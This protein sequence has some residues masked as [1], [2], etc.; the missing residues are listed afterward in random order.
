MMPLGLQIHQIYATKFHAYVTSNVKAGF[1]LMGSVLKIT[2]RMRVAMR[3]LP[4]VK[5][6]MEILQ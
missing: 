6:I 2:Q 5:R 1:A 4:F 3:H